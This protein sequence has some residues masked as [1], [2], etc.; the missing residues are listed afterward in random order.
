MIGS[1]RHGISLLV[2]TLAVGSNNYC[3][4][5]FSVSSVNSQNNIQYRQGAPKDEMKIAATLA[6]ELMNPLGIQGDRF[7]VATDASSTS[8]NNVIGWA[9]V[10]PLGKPTTSNIQRDP[11]QYNAR[12]GS[13]SLDQ[14]ID[15]AMWDDFDQDDSIQVPV[16]WASLPWTPEYRALQQAVKDRDEK[17]KALR[18]QREAALLLQQQQLWELSS[19]YVEAPYRH[20]GIGTELVRRVLRQRLLPAADQQQQLLPPPSLP[21]SIYCLTLATTAPWYEDNFGFE[22][23]SSS[24]VP[25]PMALEVAAGSIITKLIGAQLCCMR[26]TDKTV[27]L[28]C[29][30]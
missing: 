15:D 1:K 23:V 20:Q 24:D 26:G 30:K 13:Y 21:T 25:A 29:K 19:V 7:I 5:G 14:E 8:D 17:R 18:Q 22:I 10:K 12:P 3:A 28:L 4:W 6:K 2:V 9:Q 27:G 16:G 11:S